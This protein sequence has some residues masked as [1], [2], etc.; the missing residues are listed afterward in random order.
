MFAKDFYQ[1]DLRHIRLYNH[2]IY[3]L[4]EL[5][6]AEGYFTEA[7]FTLLLSASKLNWTTD[8]LGSDTKY[9]TQMEWERKEQHYKDIID[10]FEKG[11][12]R[13]TSLASSGVAS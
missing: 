5:N 4:K 11:E 7:G 12:V 10:F 3:K 1:S 6:V 8:H 9:H 13:G 2:Y